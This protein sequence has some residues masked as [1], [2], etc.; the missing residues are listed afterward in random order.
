MTKT[1][2]RL[3]EM[4]TENTGVHFLDS[5]MSNGRHWQQNQGHTLSEWQNRPSALLDTDYGT[6]VTLDV[7]GF[8]SDRLRLSEQAE[9]VQ[10]QFSEF[11]DENN[12][13]LWDCSAMEEFAQLVHEPSTLERTPE[14]VNTYN[15]ENLLSQVLQFVEFEINGVQFVL[16][17]IHGGADVRGGYTAPQVFE[18][19]SEYWIYQSTEALISCADC[20]WYATLNGPDFYDPDGLQVETKFYELKACPECQSYKL[21]AEAPEAY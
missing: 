10:A 1:Q 9:Q 18:V 19:L 14:I 21:T 4:L 20:G 17:Q 7:F 2:N 15:F 13:S 11:I 8:L 3:I 6:S 12:Y 16:L 5:G